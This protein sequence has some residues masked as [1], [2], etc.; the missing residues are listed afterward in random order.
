MKAYVIKNK[1]HGYFGVN[2]MYQHPEWS[3][4]DLAYYFKTKEEAEKF[5][6]KNYP[7]CKIVELTI[8]EGDLEGENKQLKEKIEELEEQTMFIKE[9]GTCA[10]CEK[11]YKDLGEENRA[12]KEQLA[13]K[14]KEIKELENKL[15]HCSNDKWYIDL[16]KLN[17]PSEIENQIRHQVCKEI[18]KS[19]IDLVGYETEKEARAYNCEL[20]AREVLD[21]IDQIEKGEER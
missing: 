11:L 10:F 12:L 3:S 4:I 14:D 7:T 8:T 2:N 18:R 20:N 9:K 19:I 16:D 17:I 13:E 15:E 6:N 5:K 1:V 21:E